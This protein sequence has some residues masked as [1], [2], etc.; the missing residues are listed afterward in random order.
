MEIRKTPEIEM[1]TEVTPSTE[2][3]PKA[4]DY[5]RRYDARWI[6][7]D[8]TLKVK[9]GERPIHK[10]I[11]GYTPKPGSTLTC[12]PWQTGDTVWHQDLGEGYPEDTTTIDGVLFNACGVLS[13]PN[14]EP[15]HHHPN[16]EKQ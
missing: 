10:R 2:Y 7:S 11:A 5:D 3:L 1:K 6:A 16:H 13:L 4:T 14:A 8:G 9:F 15:I 12:W